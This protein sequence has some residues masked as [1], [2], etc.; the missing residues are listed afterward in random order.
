MY[1]MMQAPFFIGSSVKRPL[2]VRDFPTRNEKLPGV[3]FFGNFCITLV[4]LAQDDECKEDTYKNAVD[5]KGNEGV[6]AHVSQKELDHKERDD[7]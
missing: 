2:P 7:K 1:S 5:S 4:Y 3:N 6:S